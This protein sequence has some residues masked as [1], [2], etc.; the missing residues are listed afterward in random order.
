MG[1][2]WRY[3]QCKQVER[4]AIDYPILSFVVFAGAWINQVVN[5]LMGQE[6]FSR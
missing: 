4:I 3:R 1:A 5:T 6:R 2:R